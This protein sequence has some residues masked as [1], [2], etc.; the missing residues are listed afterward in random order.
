[1][2]V[3][4]GNSREIPYL[5]AEDKWTSKEIRD[6]IEHKKKDAV[7]IIVMHSHEY[8]QEMS[9]RYKTG[10]IFPPLRDYERAMIK[11]PNTVELPIENIIIESCGAFVGEVES[12]AKVKEVAESMRESMEAWGNV[13]KQDL[14]VSISEMG[15]GLALM[16][17]GAIIGTALIAVIG[18]GSA[19][20]GFLHLAWATKPK[21]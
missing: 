12:I 19:G 3:L 20:L 10:I 5:A 15:I 8:E 14:A 9:R 16:L 18:F 1:M 13:T 11:R 6:Y 17:T 21:K 4:L 2:A 7:D